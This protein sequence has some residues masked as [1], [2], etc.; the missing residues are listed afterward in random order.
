MAIAL[1]TLLSRRQFDALA[2]TRLYDVALRLPLAVFYLY[3]LIAKTPSL[4]R[5]AQSL[6]AL[7]FPLLP[8]AQILARLAFLLFITLI[9]GMTLLRRRPVAKGT[10][11]AG[12]LVALGGSSLPM[13]LPLLAHG[14]PTAAMLLASAALTMLGNALSLWTLAWLGR[15]FSV[16]P[17]A[18]RP[19]MT[20]PYRRIRHPL[21]AC[22]QLALAGAVL[23]FFSVYA[24][25]LV[26]AQL[27]LQLG[28][29]GYEERVLAA[30]FP[31]YAAYRARTARLIP[32]IY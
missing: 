26:A 31:E 14:R 22:E 19:V 28:R 21:Y 2:R 5:V 30:T 8:I 24:L 1:P 18:R 16:M 9:A 10:G 12:R 29:M 11:L 7:G 20:G 17:E 13:I 6:P 32:G 3:V 25:A 23:Q 15:S 4:V 27:A